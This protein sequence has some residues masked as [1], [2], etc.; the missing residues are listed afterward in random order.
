MLS[1]R[2]RYQNNE[3][4]RKLDVFAS[5]ASKYLLADPFYFLLRFRHR[6]ALTTARDAGQFGAYL[7]SKT[8]TLANFD[9][10]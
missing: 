7:P 1:A 5:P 9:R 8:I 4:Q 6:N 10:E 2:D 3:A